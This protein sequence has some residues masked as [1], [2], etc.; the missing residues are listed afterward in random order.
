MAWGPTTWQAAWRLDYVLNEARKQ[1]ILA[2]LTVLNHH[3]FFDMGTNR[4]GW[5][6]NP[7]NVAN[8]GPLT[9][10]DQFFSDPRAF[11]YYRDLLAYILARWGEDPQIAFFNL[12]SEVDNLSCGKT[13][14]SGGGRA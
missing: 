9:E 2:I 13:D 5:L 11:P 6:G 3:Q 7:F 1:D 14:R 10:R 12:I 4:A 8:G